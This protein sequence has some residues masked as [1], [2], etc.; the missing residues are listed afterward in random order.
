[1]AHVV[2]SRIRSCQVSA[3]RA[4]TMPLKSQCYPS[5]TG[6][7]FK[8]GCSWGNEENFGKKPTEDN[9]RKDRGMCT[10]RVGHHGA[11]AFMEGAT[12]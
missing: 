10:S 8:R 11:L 12:Y 3:S 9:G 7:D 6:R 2:P 1:M 4:K 5:N